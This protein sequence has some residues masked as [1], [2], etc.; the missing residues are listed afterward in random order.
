M[1][2]KWGKKKEIAHS[3]RS[4]V[5]LTECQSRRSLY[6]CL[7]LGLEPGTWAKKGKVYEFNET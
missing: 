2:G 7:Y 6:L 1:V 5:T 3:P 4:P